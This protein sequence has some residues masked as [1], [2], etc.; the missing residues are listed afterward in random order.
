MMLFWSQLY[1]RQEEKVL[2]WSQNLCVNRIRASE[3]TIEPTS[4]PTSEMDTMDTVVDALKAILKDATARLL[5]TIFE[6]FEKAAIA[7]ITR[8]FDS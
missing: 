2:F 3:P 1:V 6:E 8:A 5:G 7:L 4:E